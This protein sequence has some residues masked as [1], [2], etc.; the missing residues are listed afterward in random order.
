MLARTVTLE[1]L[2][3]GPSHNQL[4]SPLTPLFA[5]LW[6]A[7]NRRNREPSSPLKFAAW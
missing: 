1:L 2:R 4:L 5:W 7:L 6:P 3:H